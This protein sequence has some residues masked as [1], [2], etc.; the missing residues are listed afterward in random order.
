MFLSNHQ[1]EGQNWETNRANR[2]FAN[3]LQFIYSGATV[4][5]QNLILVE[6]KRRLNS[7]NACH[8]SHHKCVFL[9][10]VNK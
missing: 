6:I 9:S 2:S 7:G 8:H 5:N 4:T 3:V 10:A 1:N